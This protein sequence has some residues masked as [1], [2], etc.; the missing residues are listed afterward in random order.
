MIFEGIYRWVKRSHMFFS[1]LLYGLKIR[2]YSRLPA[3]IPSRFGC[4]REVNS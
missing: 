2:F 3:E 4:S 1:V